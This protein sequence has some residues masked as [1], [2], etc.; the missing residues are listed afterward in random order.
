MEDN[1][2]Y[3]TLYT[4]GCTY[5]NRNVVLSNALLNVAMLHNVIITQKYL[6]VGHTQMEVDSIHA[7]IEKNLKNKVINVPAEYITICKNAKKAKPYT[8]E[9]LNY[10]YFK[11][12]INI[13][14]SNSIRPGKMKGDPK[15]HKLITFNCTVPILDL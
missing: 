6:E 3:I 14:F 4:D 5:Q 15:V 12:F 13:N 1:N 7:L 9:Y 11:N 2:R 10:S 8:V